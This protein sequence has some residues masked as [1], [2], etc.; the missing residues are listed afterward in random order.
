MVN[1]D[2]TASP[3]L[4]CLQAHRCEG[5]FVDF[6]IDLVQ[7]VY[8]GWSPLQ[9]MSLVD[10]RFGK[11]M[12]KTVSTMEAYG[13]KNSRDLGKSIVSDLSYIARKVLRAMDG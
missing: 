5:C 8:S 11:Y 10:S 9:K 7:E 6:Q 12:M 3:N 4:A 1:C 13:N 2:V